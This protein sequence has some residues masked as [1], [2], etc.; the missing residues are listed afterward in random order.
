V[1]WVFITAVFLTAVFFAVR[2]PPTK[3]FGRGL[4]I[5]VVLG[6]V[7]GGLAYLY[8]YMQVTRSKELIKPSELT[9]DVLKVER[10]GS[11]SW[12]VSGHVT[13]LSTHP[14]RQFT[15]MIQ[16]KHCPKPNSCVIIGESD[17]GVFVQVPP[18]QRRA[19][20]DTFLFDNLP[21]EQLSD[22]TVEYK[23]TEIV[24]DIHFLWY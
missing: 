7:A 19:F 13:N 22:V 23:V 24:A 2:H 9:I 11:A 6:L 16:I 3:A 20:S 8:N 10:S 14:L 5:L 12:T 4:G 15:L 17:E 1:E 21:K 18:K